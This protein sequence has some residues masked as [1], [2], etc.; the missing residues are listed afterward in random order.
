[1]LKYSFLAFA[2][3]RFMSI[4]LRV[5]AGF[6]ISAVMLSSSNPVFA[7]NT[8]GCCRVEGFSDAEYLEVGQSR[9]EASD[10]TGKGADA[11]PIDPGSWTLVVMPDTQHYSETAA[12]LP[13]FKAQT[14][15]IVD[16]EESHN[17]KYVLH[18]GDVVNVPTA[19]QQWVNARAALDTLNGNVPYAIAPGNHDY[20]TAGTA[21]NRQSL[22][23][24]PNYFGPG[25]PYATQPSIGGFLRSG[26]DR[27]LVPHVQC[28]RQ[29]LA[30]AGSGV[31]SARRG[32]RLGQPGRRS[33]SRS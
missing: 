24:Q 26:K 6:V 28:G 1:M 17:I 14:Q 8:C 33:P 2:S 15:W 30:R 9:A 29:G 13:H 20:G 19:T 4:E 12:Y 21:N 31:W 10:S 22:F 16:H 18:E 5:V 32:R 25:T 11:L 3:A 7:C 27:Q 23:H